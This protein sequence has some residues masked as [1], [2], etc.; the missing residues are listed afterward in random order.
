MNFKIWKSN[1]ALN[2]KV[3][4]FNETNDLINKDID[5]AKK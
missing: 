4:D 1:K 3:D 2:K 5:L